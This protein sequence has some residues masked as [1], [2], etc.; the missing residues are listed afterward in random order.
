[1]EHVVGMGLAAGS[2]V[3]F[4][5]LSLKARGYLRAKAAVR[6]LGRRVLDWLVAILQQQGIDDFVMITKGKENRYQIRSMLGYGDALGVRVRYSPVTQDA[7]NSGSADALLTNLDYFDIHDTAFVFP[8]DSVLD[9]DLPAMLAAHH[10]S[11]AVVTIAA[12][13]QPA[14]LIAGRY[15][16]IDCDARGRVRGFIEKP[17]L[18]EIYTHYGV[19]AETP[20]LLPPLV[21]NAGFYLVDALAL[22]EIADDPALRAQRTRHLDIGGDLLPWLVEQGYP[23]YAHRIGRM[24][25]LGNI[26]SYLETMLDVLHGRFQS[27][28]ALMPQVYPDSDYVVIDHETLEM[29][30][31]VSKLTLSE[32][33][34]RGMVELQPPLRIGKFVRIYP[35][36]RLAH[37]NIDDECEIRE[38]ST[39]VRS[40][41]GS[42]SIIGP[43]ST[44]E[45]TLTGIMVEL[46]SSREMPVMLRRYVAIGDEV[47]LRGP[48]EVSDGV[49]IFPR[50]R[51]PAEIHIPAG[52]E[53]ETS[54]QVVE[55]L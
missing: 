37:C 3:R 31:P 20:A 24:G 22:R 46:R 40:S 1:M 16:L 34:E 12:A 2:G 29:T 33:L 30:D 15:G 38:G 49:T 43:Y 11:K 23:V 6:L 45:D 36:A 55:L 27:L 47:V 5:P 10:R 21:T 13:Q 42:G 35:G 50:L 51:I 28:S 41:I 53:I 32:K 19:A 44:I 48:V 39:I 17:T 8:T 7:T 4:R 18:S 54:D 14:E 26:P 9:I 25:D 52:T